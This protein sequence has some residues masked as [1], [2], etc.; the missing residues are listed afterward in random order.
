MIQVDLHGQFQTVAQLED[1]PGGLGWTPQGRLLIVAAFTRRLLQLEGDGLGEVA[2]LSSLV[3]APNND[4]AV[5]GQGRAYI[6]N[7][8][9]CSVKA[10]LSRVRFCSSPRRAARE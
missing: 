8:G 9:T 6:G 7:R 3:S 4:L 1:M 5:D 10:H 2:D